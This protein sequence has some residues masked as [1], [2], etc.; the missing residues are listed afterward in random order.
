MYA[1]YGGGNEKKAQRSGRTETTENNARLGGFGWSKWG[2]WMN[3]AVRAV[4]MAWHIRLRGV[5]ESYLSRNLN[6]NHLHQHNKRLKMCKTREIS[7]VVITT[8]KKTTADA[9]DHK[10]YAFSLLLNMSMVFIT[11]S[12]TVLMYYIFFLQRFFLLK[13]IIIQ[14]PAGVV[15][16]IMNVF[17]GNF[18]R[19]FFPIKASILI[20]VLLELNRI[21][22]NQSLIPFVFFIFKY[23]L[24]QTK[25]GYSWS[26]AKKKQATP[27]MSYPSRSP[28]TNAHIM[29]IKAIPATI[30]MSIR[31]AK[32]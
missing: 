14:L 27:N 1:K 22:G 23:L 6:A 4:S 18:A 16:E 32:S 9:T 20:V 15:I 30:S 25:S 10:K 26:Q 17:L 5:A 11:A 29:W 28:S 13:I 21:A 3:C 12:W 2:E 7:A 8:T 19:I 24:E 31:N